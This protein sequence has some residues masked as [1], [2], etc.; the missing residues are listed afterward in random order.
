M[1]SILDFNHFSPRSLPTNSSSSPINS[2][3]DSL[4][5]LTPRLLAR[6]F[7]ASSSDSVESIFSTHSSLFTLSAKYRLKVKALDDLRPPK[8]TF[9]RTRGL[10]LPQR[11][12]TVSRPIRNSKVESMV[13]KLLATLTVNG[14]LSKSKT[15]LSTSI[16]EE[17]SRRDPSRFSLRCVSRPKFEIYRFPFQLSTSPSI[18][19]ASIPTTLSLTSSTTLIL[20]IPLEVSTFRRSSLALVVME[21]R[22][23]N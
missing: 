15:V 19:P 6:T 22:T 23:A 4:L 11:S 3:L 16:V 18:P 10:K 8:P 12:S 13:W 1:L 17:W 20:S 14:L 21:S 5:L 9:Q 7:D 2:Q